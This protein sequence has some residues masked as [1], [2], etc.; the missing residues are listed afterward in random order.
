MLAERR[1]THAV[2]ST[3]DALLLDTARFRNS[4]AVAEVSG[5][6]SEIALATLNALACIL[7]LFELTPGHP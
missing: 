6:T 7:D 4:T 1:L 5:L 2:R 3:L